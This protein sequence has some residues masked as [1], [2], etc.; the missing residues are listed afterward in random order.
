MVRVANGRG[1]YWNFHYSE[2]SKQHTRYMGK[3]DDPEARVDE[4]M[5]GE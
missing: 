1:P 4:L 5:R 3:T 2:G